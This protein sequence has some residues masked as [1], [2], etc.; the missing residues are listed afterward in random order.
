MRIIGGTHKGRRFNVPR[1]FKS[2]PTTDLARESLLNIL[3]N[4]YDFDTLKAI[5]LFAGTGALSY[6]FA[7][8]GME[9]VL[10]VESNFKM[11]NFIKQESKIFDFDQIKAIKKNVFRFLSGQVFPA[12]IIFADPPYDLKE[13]ETLPQLIFDND[14]LNSNGCF[15]LE[16]SKHFNFEK[17]PHFYN[18]KK[19]GS[20]HFSF[21]FA[22]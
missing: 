16:H 19:Y 20:V 1:S 15:I 10:A 4:S 8:R 11:Y 14:W 2:R 3:L 5:D 13:I 21:F 18:V 6:E 9:S 22:D 7:S 17:F 12:D